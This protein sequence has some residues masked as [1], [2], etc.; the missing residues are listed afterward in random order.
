MAVQQTSADFVAA[1]HTPLV[2]AAGSAPAAQ[3]WQGCRN[4][5]ES[6]EPAEVGRR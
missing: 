6:E 5:Q 1:S 2:G 3:E 4:H